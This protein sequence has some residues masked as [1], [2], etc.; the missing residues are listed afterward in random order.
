MNNAHCDYKLKGK[1]KFTIMKIQFN[2]ILFCYKNINTVFI[3]HNIF[4]NIFLLSFMF[5]NRLGFHRIMRLWIKFLEMQISG[6]TSPKQ[7]M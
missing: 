6:F 7:I 4:L 3:M 5:Q 1:T 2:C